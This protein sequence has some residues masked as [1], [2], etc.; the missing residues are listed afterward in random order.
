[1]PNTKIFTKGIWLKTITK[2]VAKLANRCL[3][4]AYVGIV[5]NLDSRFSVHILLLHHYMSDFAH[6]LDLYSLV[7]GIYKSEIWAKNN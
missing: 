7:I 1:M 4:G 5:K 3:R 2:K 6:I